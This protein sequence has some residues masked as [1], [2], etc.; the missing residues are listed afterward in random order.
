MSHVRS[1]QIDAYVFR[2]R[3][4]VFRQRA[5]DGGKVFGR[6]GARDGL[7]LRLAFSSAEAA[8]PG[9]PRAFAK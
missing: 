1:S 7:Q 8:P 5:M 2:I 3:A 4:I 6:R 9:Q